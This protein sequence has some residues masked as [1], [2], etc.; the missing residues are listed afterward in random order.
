ME[1]LSDSRELASGKIIDLDQNHPDV[2]ALLLLMEAKYHIYISCPVI[3]RRR[4]TLAGM[5][6]GKER[7]KAR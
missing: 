6:K 5:F 3:E 7:R 1:Y 2:F 4:N